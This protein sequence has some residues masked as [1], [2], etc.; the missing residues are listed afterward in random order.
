L[1]GKQWLVGGAWLSVVMAG[2]AWLSLVVAGGAWLWTHRR[3]FLL[4]FFI[5][6]IT[7]NSS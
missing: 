1:A 7:V 6:A 4:V 5:A 3:L 2:G